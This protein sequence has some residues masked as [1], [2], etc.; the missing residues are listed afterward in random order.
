MLTVEVRK[1]E[2]GVTGG[3]GEEVSSYLTRRIMRTRPR[4]MKGGT[5]L[6]DILITENVIVDGV[7]TVNLTMYKQ[8]NKLT[9]STSNDPFTPI[10]NTQKL[11]ETSRWP[12][13]ETPL[14]HYNKE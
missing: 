1:R 10:V 14:A 4:T 6:T 12:S 2:T 13:S 3:K 8:T 7:N 9:R 5:V 11:H